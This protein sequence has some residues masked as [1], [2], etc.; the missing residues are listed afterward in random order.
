MTIDRL[1]GDPVA[2]AVAFAFFGVVFGY[3]IVMSLWITNG[4]VPRWAERRA[5]PPNGTVVLLIKLL[6]FLPMLGA[7]SWAIPLL[8][9]VH[10]II[11]DGN[12]WGVWLFFIFAISTFLTLYRKVFEIKW[13]EYG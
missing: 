4:L 12:H 2:W 1:A 7:L 9:R 11:T 6:L 3:A 13:R 5:L 8:M 10:K